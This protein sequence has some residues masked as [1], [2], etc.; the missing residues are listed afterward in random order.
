[1]GAERKVAEKDMRTNAQGTATE[2]N[3][4]IAEG[5]AVEKEIQ[6]DVKSIMKEIDSA[7]AEEKAA[8]EKDMQIGVKSITTGTGI[9]EK[10]VGLNFQGNEMDVDMVIGADSVRGK[11]AGM[12]T[13]A[14][15]MREE[16]AEW[17]M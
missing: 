15:L 6:I 12:A 4:A 11:V 3:L 14:D 13:E 16:A 8:A 17:D 9:T 1:M 10:E 2:I 5:K 7:I